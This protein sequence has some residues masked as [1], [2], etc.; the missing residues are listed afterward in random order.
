MG[1]GGFASGRG[2]F[3]TAK[4]YPKRRRGHPGP[5]V[6]RPWRL[7]LLPSADS[8]FRCETCLSAPLSALTAP[9]RAAPVGQRWRGRSAAHLRSSA[10]RQRGA[11]LVDA[12]RHNTQRKE[13]YPNR[14]T[15][16]F[17]CSANSFSLGPA[18]ARLSPGQA[19]PHSGG[20]PPIHACGRSLFSKREWGAEIRS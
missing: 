3:S 1:R 11:R 9:L 6:G 7:S 8:G 13:K 17:P 4:K 5:R 19:P 10:E 16:N 15:G 14:E 20:C 12:G 2:T 18:A